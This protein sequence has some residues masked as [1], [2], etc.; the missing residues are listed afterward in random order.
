MRRRRLEISIVVV[1][2]VLVLSFAPS[3][4]AEFK[5]GGRVVDESGEPIAAASV[6]VLK[7]TERLSYKDEVAQIL[8]QA[9][10]QTDGSGRFSLPLEKPP[11]IWELYTLA[12]RHRDY[13][14]ALV[15]NYELYQRRESLAD[16]TLTVTKPGCIKG[17]VT[18]Q[19]GNPVSGA[20]VVP[21]VTIDLF[22]VGPTTVNLPPCEQLLSTTTGAYGTFVVNELPAKARAALIVSHPNFATTALGSIYDDVG[23][24][25]QVGATDVEVKLE[26]GATIEGKV[27]FQDTGR[28]VEGAL[29]RAVP[30]PTESEASVSRLAGRMLVGTIKAKTDKDGRYIVRGVPEGRYGVE[31]EYPDW[32]AEAKQVLEISK[33]ARLIDQNFVLTKGVLVSGRFMIAETGTPVKDGYI[34]IID[35]TGLVKNGGTRQP[36][37]AGADGTFQFRQPPGNV[38]FS[39]YRVLSGQA[40]EQVSRQRLTLVA[41]RDVTDIVF[42]AEQTATLK[43]KVLGPQGKP[44]AGAQVWAFGATLWTDANGAFELPLV[45]HPAGVIIDMALEA[46]H[47]NLPGYR[48]FLIK[49]FETDPGTERVIEMKPAATLTGRVVDNDGKPVRSA[50]VTA[51]QS[52]KTDRGRSSSLYRAVRCDDAGRYAIKDL[53]SGGTY[54]VYAMA[55]G[56]GQTRSTEF[57]LS[58]GEVRAVPDLVLRIAAIMSI[59]GTVTDEDGTPLANAQVSCDGTATGY[60]RTCTDEKGRYRFEH[61]VDE[62]IRIHALARGPEGTLQGNFRTAAGDRRA[63]IIVTEEAPRTAEER[64]ARRLIGKPAHE[65]NVTSCINCEPVTLGCLAG[66]TVLLAFWDSSNEAC[67]RLAALLNKLMSDYTGKAVE[68]VSVHSADADVKALK[69]VLSNQAIKFRV[70]LDKPASDKRYKGATFQRYGVKSLPALYIVSAKGWVRYQDVPLPA[71]EQALKNVLEQAET[72]APAERGWMPAPEE[73]DP[74]IASCA[75]N[76]KQIGLALKIFANEHNGRFPQIDNRRGNLTVEGDD[77]VPKYLTDV[78]VFRCPTNQNHKPAQRPYKGDDVT[79][80]SYF[81]L[82]WAVSIEQDGLGLLDAYESLDL[83]Q[84]DADIPFNSS[85]GYE[86]L[87]RFR[88]G[89]E[90]FFITDINDPTAS[91]RAQA[92]LPVMWERPGHHSLNGGNVLYMDGHIEFV[93]YPGKFPMTP[94]FIKRCEAISGG[95]R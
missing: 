22:D 24:T 7:L 38:A 93:P 83:S 78:N 40:P 66:K 8:V 37:Q 23:G 72:E 79:D 60:R 46:C 44:L 26:R 36:I 57:S 6:Y 67:T 70:A 75:N 28:P 74:T 10:T 15:T 12:A 61:V 85:L 68:I 65:L 86:K 27:T 63:D 47:P 1:L 42:K 18:D 59:E 71:L 48:G 51:H 14:L 58:E 55:E 33:G 43:G 54:F 69:Q 19:E 4:L 91:A 39:A 34:V 50:S 81:Y 52:F 49:P 32:T 82:G 17:R 9:Q 77:I 11:T 35:G 87:Y 88:E 30:V 73:E 64:D 21:T 53:A 29:I 95:N 41:G 80:Q 45:R 84:R 31:V 92:Q 25:V 2:S 20:V 5:V 3:A 76:L 62:E 16:I 89:I 13:G 94:A 56:Y 90:R